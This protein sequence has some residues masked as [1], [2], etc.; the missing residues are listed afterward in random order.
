MGRA[1]GVDVG[2]TKILAGLVGEDGTLSATT[3]CPTPS[4]D[5][6]A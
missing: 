1:I 3:R 2:G 4:T 6:E 5:P